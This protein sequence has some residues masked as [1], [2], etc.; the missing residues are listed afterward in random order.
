MP[1]EGLPQRATWNI[2]HGGGRRDAMVPIIYVTR[3]PMQS[4]RQFCVGHYLDRRQDWSRMHPRRRTANRVHGMTIGVLKMQ[5][6]QS[7]HLARRDT[8]IPQ[9]QQRTA[10]RHAVEHTPF[11]IEAEREL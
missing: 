3:D 6:R 11:I 8:D 5:M 2:K 7:P 9:H 10:L 1:I 4:R